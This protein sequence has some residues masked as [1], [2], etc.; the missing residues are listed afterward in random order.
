M[1]ASAPEVANMLRYLEGTSHF[2]VKYLAFC[3]TVSD[4][5]NRGGGGHD[6]RKALS[7][8]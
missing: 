6:R 5:G 2:F 4:E 3:V 7:I 1:N 8:E